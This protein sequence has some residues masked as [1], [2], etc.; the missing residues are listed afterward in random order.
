MKKLTVFFLLL[1]FAAGTA[2]AQDEGNTVT[3]VPKSKNLSFERYRPVGES[4]L[5]TFVSRD[6]TL[7]TLSSV[8]KEATE[9]NGRKGYVLEEKLDI[10]MERREAR[11]AFDI[12]GEH[13]VSNEGFYLGDK[14]KLKINEFDEKFEFKLDDGQLEG[15]YTRSGKKVKKDIPLEPDRFAWETYFV[16]Q[17]ELFWAMHDFKVGDT[18]RDTIYA[19]QSM[20][21]TALVGTVDDFVYKEIYRNKFDSVFVIHL[22][23]PQEYYLYITARKHLVRTDF[24]Q[25]RIRAYLD[26]VD[27]G[28]GLAKSL[29]PEYTMKTFVSTLPSYVLYLVFAVL[30]LLFLVRKGFVWGRAY[31]ALAAGIVLYLVMLVTQFPLQKLAIGKIILPAIASGGSLYIWGLLPSLIVGFVQEGLMLLAVFL[32]C[33]YG[34]AKESRYVVIGAFCGAGFG[35]LEACYLAAPSGILGAFSLSLLE[36]GFMI[37]FHTAAGALLGFAL[38]GSW[39]K[40]AAFAVGL[41]IINTAL[42]YMPIFV[43]QKDVLVGVMYFALAFL[44]LIILGLTVALLNKKKTS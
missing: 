27:K 38:R 4:R 39:F 32:L 1:L 26:R 18:I 23:A 28:G 19:Q 16:D 5:W 31:L 10:K 36:N 14:L 9:I 11:I 12:E 6:T 22:T 35:F 7:G 33:Y 13:Y 37:I 30:S 41:M 8:V 34:S 43:Q 40:A 24:P 21:Q 3:P 20:Y 29:K 44:V 15:F 17:L 2:A 25:Y 42:R